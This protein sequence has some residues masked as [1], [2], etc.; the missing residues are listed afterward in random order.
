MRHFF[1]VL[2]GDEGYAYLVTIKL[3]MTLGVLSLSLIYLSLT[4]S[5]HVDSIEHSIIH[6]NCL[7]VGL[8]NALRVT[9][10]GYRRYTT[11]KTDSRSEISLRGYLH[12]NA[13]KHKNKLHLHF[14]LA[15]PIMQQSDSADL[16][17]TLSASLWYSRE[18]SLFLLLLFLLSV[19]F[20]GRR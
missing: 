5:K 8:W 2:T 19:Y 11:W 16:K 6:F 10:V 1:G 15:I 14:S 9:K 17:I 4:S 12:V 13:H 18:G 3:F 7:Y 20:V